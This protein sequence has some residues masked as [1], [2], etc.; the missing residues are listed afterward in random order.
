MSETWQKWEIRKYSMNMGYLII[1][2]L[3]GCVK[4]Y[5][6]IPPEWWIGINEK[7]NVYTE[8]FTFPFEILVVLIK[9]Y[10]LSI[11]WVFLLSNFEISCHGQ[12]YKKEEMDPPNF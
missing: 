7:I 10:K 3:L 4:G 6:A 11:L 12:R 5:T 8:A 2:V 9:I 1:T